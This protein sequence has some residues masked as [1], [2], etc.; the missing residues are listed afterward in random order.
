MRNRKRNVTA[1]HVTKHQWDDI[2]AS[3]GHT[4]EQRLLFHVLESAIQDIAYFQIEPACDA[5]CWLLS[6]RTGPYTFRYV[7]DHLNISHTYLRKTICQ[8]VMTTTSSIFYMPS[9]LLNNQKSSGSLRKH[10]QLWQ[11]QAFKQTW[12]RYAVKSLKRMD[13]KIKHRQQAIT[14][15]GV[16]LEKYLSISVLR[17]KPDGPTTK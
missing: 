1:D 2:W 9:A 7:C 12:T 14:T 6:D 16:A 17:A 13:Q 11:T 4:R 3:P 8:K 15:A 5:M 10:L